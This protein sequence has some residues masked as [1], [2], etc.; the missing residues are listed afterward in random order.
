MKPELASLL[1][2]A[3]TTAAISSP[4]CVKRLK[5]LVAE[6]S[7]HTGGG[8]GGRLVIQSYKVAGERKDLVACAP[9]FIRYSRKNKAL[10]AFPPA[11][12]GPFVCVRPDLCTVK[13]GRAV[14]VIA[15]QTLDRP[16]E[17]EP[18]KRRPL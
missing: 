14:E 11:F 10:P 8:G 18:F 12:V 16:A 17:W 9:V 1:S 5:G 15:V 6:D 4:L 2:V 3:M 13:V 7:A